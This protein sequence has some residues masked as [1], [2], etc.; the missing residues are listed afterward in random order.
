MS[1]NQ[2]LKT[3]DEYRFS[4]L[5]YI[6]EAALEYFV[7]M[8]VTG[9]YLA[10][11]TT[12]L[13][14][15]DSTTALISAF[16]SLGFCFQVFALMIP[17]RFSSKKLV[18]PGQLVSQLLF[19]FLYVLPFF[20]ISSNAKSALL[21]I[22]ML[23][24]RV[25]TNFVYPSRIAWL[26]DLVEENNRGKFTAV[27]EMVSLI[28][29]M[30]FTLVMGRVIDSYRERGDE[31]GALLACG[32][33]LFVMTVSYTLTLIFTKEKKFPE[34]ELKNGT[35]KAQLIGIIRCKNFW[36]ILPVMM[37]WS[38]ASYAS[39]PFYSTYLISELAFDFFTIS[40]I[41]TVGA[42]ARSVFSLPLGAFAD[43]YGFSK[44]LFLCFALMFFAFGGM[45]FTSPE[46]RYFYIVYMILHSISMAGMN[47]SEINLVL[48]YTSHTLRVGAIAIKG[49]I[50]GIVGFLTTL[51]LKP[52]VD[53]IQKNGNTIFG[54]RMYAQQLT[55]II[56][57]AACIIALIYMMTVVRKLKK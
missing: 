13:G 2:S 5:M 15:S 43:K 22:A 9:T 7:S 46:R 51:A 6:I 20:T 37:L 24:A 54:V 56:S 8:M 35:T 44:M 45:I 38:I 41:S 36:L 39:T 12:H 11:L 57:V 33:T 48:D 16:V 19:T 21:I 26:M 34:E 49:L 23:S 17:S 30:A 47:S 40:I 29:G 50:C 55:S 25:I 28:S 31:R 32:I 4:R 27:K 10:L 42:A 53:F 1:T 18:I 52:L 3:R 14:I